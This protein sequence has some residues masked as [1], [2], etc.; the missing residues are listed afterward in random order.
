MYIRDIIKIAGV[1]LTALAVPAV[2]IAQAPDQRGKAQQ[3][4]MPLS[5]TDV[6]LKVDGMS[7]SF[8]A[9][10]LEKRLNEIEAIDTLVIR[11]SD[12]LVHIRFKDGQTVEDEALR[13]AV[14]EAGFTLRQIERIGA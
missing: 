11:V 7:C 5:G 9:Y 13:E 14:H 10:G 3:P 8:C 1:A 12:G 6:V 4:D 2:G